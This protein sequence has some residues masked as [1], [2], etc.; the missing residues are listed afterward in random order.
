MHDDAMGILSSLLL[1]SDFYGD[2]HRRLYAAM[3]ERHERGE[4]CDCLTISHELGDELGEMGGIAWLSSLI[5][6][7]PRVTN[8]DGWAEIVLGHSWRRQLMRLGSQLSE[9]ASDE[10]NEIQELLESYSQQI[11]KISA[12]T[13][14]SVVKL[15]D[16]LPASIK[17][18]ETFV[19]TR[20]RVGI[21]TGWDDVD[22]AMGGGFCPGRMYF[23]AA[24]SGRGKSSAVMQWAAAAAREGK[25]LLVFATEMIPEDVGER[26]LCHQG[27][28]DKWAVFRDESQWSRVSLAVGEIRDWPI[29]IDKRETPTIGQIAA[30]CRQFQL[31]RGL[32]MVIVDHVQRL[33]VD[34]REGRWLGVGLAVQGLKS[35]S[36]RLG[37]PVL[38]TSQLS[39][40]EDELK[41]PHCGML[42]Q[43]RQMIEA[44]SD[45][46][47]FLHPTSRDWRDE[48]STELEFFFEKSRHGRCASF[49]LDWNK[50]T[51]TMTM[52]GRTG[53]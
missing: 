37:I 41:K 29:W 11:S 18:I 2:S 25:R 44:E 12:A 39:S 33:T 1:P 53:R 32:D 52:K 14:G 35:L 20:G 9:R 4:K 43:S 28:T 13:G 51:H 26:L 3:F 22:R 34:S 16:I 48:L 15:S 50:P 31:K 24:R 30:T 10:G 36:M 38:V 45:V 19:Q 23:L 40:G 47:G 17:Q 49:L 27:A 21:S 8:I 46:I 5:D 7:L 42:A 6:G